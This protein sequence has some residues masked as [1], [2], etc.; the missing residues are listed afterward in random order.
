MPQS[1]KTIPSKIK[2]PKTMS[3]P[4]ASLPCVRIV[5]IIGGTK[6]ADIAPSAKIFRNEFGIFHAVK[7]A[8][9]SAPAPI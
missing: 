8:S 5:C 6:A 1:T 7:K 4:T 2:N 9:A 3:P